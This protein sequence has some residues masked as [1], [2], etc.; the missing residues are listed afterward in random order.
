MAFLF[1]GFNKTPRKHTVFKEFELYED[2]LTDSVSN[3]KDVKLFPQYDFPQQPDFLE[4]QSLS[5]SFAQDIC[6]KSKHLEN[7]LGI[8]KKDTF[9]EQTRLFRSLDHDFSLSMSDNNVSEDSDD[10]IPQ[11]IIDE[12]AN[13]HDITDVLKVADQ[14]TV[15]RTQQDSTVIRSENFTTSNQEEIFQNNDSPKTLPETT[16]TEKYLIDNIPDETSLSSDDSSLDTVPNLNV[17]GI[18]NTLLSRFSESDVQF[19]PTKTS[20]SFNSEFCRKL[21]QGSSDL[22]NFIITLFS[23]D[24]YTML[25]WLNWWLLAARFLATTIA[26][27]LPNVHLEPFSNVINEVD[28]SHLHIQPSDTLNVEYSVIFLH[29]NGPSFS[30]FVE[31]DGTFHLPH[32]LSHEFSFYGL[33]CVSSQACTSLADQVRATF[34]QHQRILEEKSVSVDAGVIIPSIGTSM[35]WSKGRRHALSMACVGAPL[36]QHQDNTCFGRFWIAIS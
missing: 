7:S 5:F 14:I 6:I 4:Q 26:V 33:R 12:I 23:F 2:F 11:D 32:H 24:I 8:S 13:T 17:V 35:D 36:H 21:V 3:L 18:V 16:V 9:F 20:L 15:A 31:N 28:V 1:K 30:T 22:C 25:S 19:V 27:I 34:Q 29:C 10:S